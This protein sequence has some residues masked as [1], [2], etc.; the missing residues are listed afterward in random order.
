M[1]DRKMTDQESDEKAI[2]VPRRTSIITIRMP[3]SYRG[4]IMIV[5]VSFIAFAIAYLLTDPYLKPVTGILAVLPVATAGWLLG[6]W[7]GLI[8]AV[9]VFPLIMIL[10]AILRQP[11]SNAHQTPS[12]VVI[13]VLAVIGFLI[14]KL[15]DIGEQLKAD[16]KTRLRGEMEFWGSKER[17]E[18]IDTAFTG[19]AVTDNTERL[20][21]CNTTFADLLGYIPD[22]LQGMLY[23]YFMEPGDLSKIDE[24]IDLMQR[25]IP[26]QYE[27]SMRRKDGGQ[28]VMLVSSV[29]RFSAYGIYN[30][31]LSIIFDITDR[32]QAEEA[33]KESEEKFRILAEQSPNMIF[34]NKIGK[35]V[36]VNPLCEEKMG[37][38]VEEFYS[39]DF[40]FMDLIAPESKELIRMNFEQ[41]KTGKDIP[42]YEYTL[43][44][45]EGKKIEA[46]ITTKLIHYE[47]AHALLG[48]IT[49]VTDRIKTDEALRASE[50]RYRAIFEQAAD[51][52][53]LIDVDSGDLVE[54]NDQMCENLGYTREEFKS[55]KISDF[56]VIES[57]EEIEK[58][59][60]QIIKGGRD[61]F[62]TKHRT[63]DGS[64][65]DIQVSS[66]Y[67]SIHGKD[68]IQ[69]IA[70]DIT[71]RV[72]MVEAL[73]GSEEKYRQLI[74]N[75]ND[76][77]Y[78]TD[79]D[80]NFIF[81]NPV[82][83]KIMGYSEKELIGTN[84]IDLLHPDWQQETDRFYRSQFSEKIL[85]TYHEF[86][87]IAKDG[88]E[89]W[90]GQNV[91]L[92]MEGEQILGFQAVARD[93]TDRKQ[94][95][96]ALRDSE[97]R[98]K[99]LSEVSLEGILIHE[100]GKIVDTNVAFARMFGYDHSEL[101]GMNALDFTTPELREKAA[102]HMSTGSE[103]IYQGI[104]IRK[105]GS[106]LQVEVR[107]KNIPSEGRIIRAV[108]VRDITE[109]K[110]M[111]EALRKSKEEAVRGQD[112]LLAL[113]DAAQA[114][115][116]VR[117]PEE[118]YRTVGE[119]MMQI[120]FQTGIFTLSEDRTHL[121]PSYLSYA[122]KLIKRAEK[123]T[124][125]SAKDYQFQ[126]EEG[127]FF[128]RVIAEG[129]TEFTPE[130][131]DYLIEGLPKS[132]RKMGKQVAKILGIEQAILAPLRYGGTIRDLLFVTG[133]NLVESDAI[134][135]SAFGNQTAIALET[136]LLF[137]QAN[138]DQERL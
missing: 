37:Y 91:Q 54:F 83:E 56:E 10:M 93:I 5:G 48:I 103:E 41:H 85:N 92:S 132:V 29:P 115:Q 108:G 96:E 25:G 33:L 68:Y 136:S 51:S 9:I 13:V 55:L 61:Q 102:Q 135:I 82:A 46:I 16:L 66:S 78:E 32:K 122:P 89:I 34:I 111:E 20:L 97:E 107:G 63:K 36:Y 130:G 27:V 98:F 117:T 77:I 21:Y 38:T 15:R 123:I 17:Y 49:D 71:D 133:S 88:A 1:G 23:N 81:I 45:K 58:H 69:T 131:I 39:P 87:A 90:F 137:H 12:L 138:T 44:T 6:Q 124:G 3:Q 26:T 62:A 19:I 53:A 118:I 125:F 52:I 50:E 73:R 8:A 2:E 74:E 47:E 100:E 106:T 121:R 70:R 101:I 14:G 72:E 64:I 119:E 24:H 31:A 110:R 11:V 120:G 80:G 84:F 18:V 30:G 129:K 113:S 95:E 42:P 57:P 67:I 35:V 43:M 112:L 76:I 126:I 104:A 134:A 86:P 4:R 105:D 109:P 60:K 22:E 40:D 65:R 116:R 59:I 28:R 75:A 128:D 127:G 114:V 99:R 94:V 7:A 79:I